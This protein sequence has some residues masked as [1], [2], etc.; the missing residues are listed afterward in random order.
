VQNNMTTPA[1]GLWWEGFTEITDEMV[2]SS[3]T[4]IGSEGQ[5]RNQWNEEVTR[6]TLFHAAVGFGD[7]NPLWID[8]D[9]ARR[10]KWGRRVAPSC[11]MQSLI[12][13]TRLP[14][15]PVGRPKRRSVMSGMAGI[16]GYTLGQEITWCD[17]PI[18]EGD[19]LRVTVRKVASIDSRGDVPG[20]RLDDV[21]MSLPDALAAWA[22]LMS[23]W[24][25]RTVLEV[26]E[27]KVWR[28]PMG[29]PST[30]TG[31]LAARV[32]AYSVRL[33]RGLNPA[34]GPYRDVAERSYSDSE[35]HEI[36]E[37]YAAERRR[38]QDP[39][40]WDEVFE[41]D[42]IQPRLRGPLTVT[43]MRAYAAGV[44]SNFAMG[45]GLLFRYLGH[46]PRANCP[47][48]A[49]NVPD[50]PNRIHW[51]VDLAN[52]IGMPFGY[53][54]GPMRVH[55]FGSYMTDWIGDEGYLQHLSA[56]Y[57]SPLF[58]SDTFIMNGEVVAKRADD[59]GPCVDLALTGHDGSGKEITR[60][61]ATAVLAVPS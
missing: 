48:L 37:G 13:G 20:D 44:G 23:G 55:W 53:D 1:T 43:A 15:D 36:L 18:R 10:S 39:L 46:S 38:G 40:A 58:L 11:F 17:G 31:T 33:P 29:E 50:I 22:D 30:G 5:L 8:A 49:T 35:I 4:G 19:R 60:G 14:V 52:T 7:D 45:D 2:A 57:H 34:D 12:Y 6:D 16:G 3:R 47:H 26:G 59:A 61:R 42:K 54:I 41:G 56:F 51:D 24:D 28:S 9:Y 25:A 32:I 21:E 27:C